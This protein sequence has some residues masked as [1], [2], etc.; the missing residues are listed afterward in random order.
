MIASGSSVLVSQT[1]TLKAIAYKDAS[2]TSAVSSVSFTTNYS[3]T[4]G[5][6]YQDD[7]Q[8]ND[9][10]LR[11]TTD[12]ADAWGQP[13][14]YVSL[15][16]G[17]MGLEPVLGDGNQAFNTTGYLN[18]AFTNTSY[19]AQVSFEC[20]NNVAPQLNISLLNNGWGSDSGGGELYFGYDAQFYNQGSVVMGLTRCNADGSQTAL[21]PEN[22]GSSIDLERQSERMVDTDC[23]CKC[24]AGGDGSDVY[25][26]RHYIEHRDPDKLFHLIPGYIGPEMD[27]RHGHRDMRRCRLGQQFQR[28]DYR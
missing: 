14:Q 24:A 1:L 13:W 12:Q 23:Q 20:P 26:E 2:T 11:Y 10:A 25:V 19:I 8:Y 22:W 7:F 17:D 21:V 28:H 15:A 4:F 9:Y 27:D 5:Y 3:S 16:G 18:G 6:I